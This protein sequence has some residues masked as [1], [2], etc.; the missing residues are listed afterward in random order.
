[1]KIIPTVIRIADPGHLSS[2]SHLGSIQAATLICLSI[3][4]LILYM[5]SI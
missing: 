2:H 4:V 3:S 5:I 1:M